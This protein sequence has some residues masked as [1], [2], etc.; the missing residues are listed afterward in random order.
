MLEM[1]DVWTLLVG[2]VIGFGMGVA[3]MA[4][5]YVAGGSDRAPES[6]AFTHQEM[7][8]PLNPDRCGL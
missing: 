1:I 5:L 8:H 3:T 7:S 6:D 2:M 4:I